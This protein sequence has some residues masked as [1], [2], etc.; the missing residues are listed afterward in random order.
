[1][2]LAE[3]IFTLRKEAGLSQE[4]L[5]ERLNLSRQ[6]ISKWES[7]QSQ[8][9]INHI[10]K[11]SQIFNVTTDFL[12]KEEGAN[13]NPD[14]K[15]FQTPDTKKR[16]H[17]VILLEIVYIINFAFL[18]YWW[19]GEMYQLATPLDWIGFFL[20]IASAVALRKVIQLKKEE[21]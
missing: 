15:V 3:K 20:L 19:V 14:D 4:Q 9:E 2:T 10:V 18:A 21:K 5:A 16:V 6:S 1:M 11:L 8:P 17:L 12:L 7:G 13:T